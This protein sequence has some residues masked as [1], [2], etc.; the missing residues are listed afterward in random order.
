LLDPDL[1]LS[2]AVSKSYTIPRDLSFH[3]IRRG[4]REKRRK[5]DVCSPRQNSVCAPTSV[6]PAAH[7]CER[8]AI[9]LM[10]HSRGAVNYIGTLRTYLRSDRNL[11]RTAQELFTHRTTLFYRLNRIKKII[12]GDLDDPDYKFRM[13]I[14]LEL[15]ENSATQAP[16]A[17]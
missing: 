15:L 9:E 17:P 7:F 11:L 4:K 6:L 2:S 12:D 8:G 3:I 5:H 10:E 1:L 13:M 16:R 14:S